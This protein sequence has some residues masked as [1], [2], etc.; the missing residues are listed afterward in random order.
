MGDEE[1]GEASTT[2]D[3]NVKSKPADKTASLISIA[4]I[5]DTAVHGFLKCQSG[6]A[7]ANAT[8]DYVIGN[9]ASSV[10]TDND[11]AFIIQ[12]QQGLKIIISYGGNNTTLACNTT[13]TINYSLSVRTGTT[14]LANNYT[15]YAVDYYA[16]ERG[17]NFTVQLKDANGNVLSN[18]T[19][20]I[21]YNGKTLERTTNATG[22]V[23]V[24]INLKD[25]NR[26]TFAV[27]F[28]GDNVYDAT[29]SVYVI[30]INK[31]P[32]TISASAKKFK[33]TAKTKKYTVTLKTIKGSS[34]DGKT[35]FGGAKKVTLTINGKTFT[36][37]T[38]KKGQATF[39]ITNLNK[40]GKFTAS[41]SYAGDKT[42]V[43]TKKSV[44]I[45]V[46]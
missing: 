35:Y 2:V 23:N 17:Q 4:E 18:K 41:I 31:K 40:K 10:L 22:H 14:L 16:G 43:A 15:Q 11:G 42:Y 37:K 27:V 32:I 1:Y 13:I 8:V 36:A 33:A 12:G 19:V 20:L 44:K 5:N 24:Q 28:L 30:A 9:K 39:K 38:N 7:I 21:G 45:T 25:A 34:A 26:L 46:N 6:R 3:I 29:M